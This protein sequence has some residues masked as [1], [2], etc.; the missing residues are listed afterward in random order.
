[1]ASQVDEHTFT[2]ARPVRVGIWK[3]PMSAATHLM[4]MLAG[5]LGTF[6]LVFW[7]APDRTQV[8]SV[9]FYGTTLV[10]LFFSSTIYHFL[11]IGERGNAWLRRL[12]HGAIFLFI[13]GTYVPA[14]VHL[15]DGTWRVA[16]LALVLGF[17][18]VGILFK[19]VW[20][21][22]PNALSTAI[23]VIMGWLIVIPGHRILPGL[24]W[25]MIGLLFGGGVLYTGGAVI[26][27]IERPNPWPEHFGFHE[28]WHLF[29][30]GGAFLHY[31]FVW[32]LLELPYA[33]F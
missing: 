33:P 26:D 31:I 13:A 7:A 21:R 14:L 24:S 4:G 10:F 2:P 29:V 9:L 22:C 5:L 17:A 3:D 6:A 27:V 20:I 25:E 11:D 19:M 32:K 12:D 23:Y 8:T 15:L 18:L 28:V 1:M 16:M 30:L